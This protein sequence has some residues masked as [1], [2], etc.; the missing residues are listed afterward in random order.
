MLCLNLTLVNLEQ[1]Q[2]NDSSSLQVEYYYVYAYHYS[3]CNTKRT[4]HSYR[5]PSLDLKSFRTCRHTHTHT[6]AFEF[7][8]WGYITQQI[9]SQGQS[10]G[11][12]KLHTVPHGSRW[13][14]H[15]VQL[16]FCIAILVVGICEACVLLLK[17]TICMFSLCLLS[18]HPFSINA[19]D[20]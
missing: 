17:F 20:I 14:S 11:Q 5:S 3:T 2:V 12:C 8:D 9:L 16:R 6:P 13:A 1:C 7:L 18:E 19:A 10:R 4:K 15:E